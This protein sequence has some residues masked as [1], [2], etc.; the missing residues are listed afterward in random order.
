MG[1]RGLAS[2]SRRPSSAGIDT[3]LI[4]SEKHNSP[5]KCYTPRNPTSPRSR[6]SQISSLIERSH[7]GQSPENA[8]IG[9]IYQPEGVLVLPE[10]VLVLPEGVLALI[11]LHPTTADFPPHPTSATN[12]L[13]V[14]PCCHFGDGIILSCDHDLTF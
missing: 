1:A 13:C 14:L 5:L 10:G 12:S 9:P 4:V 11:A 8:S 6:V 2:S 7:R 3:E